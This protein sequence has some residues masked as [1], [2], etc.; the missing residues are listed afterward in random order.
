LR[1]WT[2]LLAALA[3]LFGVFY[4]ILIAQT[5]NMVYFLAAI[6]FP[7]LYVDLLWSQFA[8]LSLPYISLIFSAGIAVITGLRWRS[9]ENGRAI[10]FY[11][12]IVAFALASFNLVI[13][14]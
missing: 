6:P 3:S 8:M 1:I 10:C 14:M 2:E 9:Q 4:L 7:R 5:P 13:L 11:Y 12:W